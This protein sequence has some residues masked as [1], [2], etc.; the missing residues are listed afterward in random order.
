MITVILPILS[1]LFRQQIIHDVYACSIQLAITNHCLFVP[2]AVAIVAGDDAVVIAVAIAFSPFVFK[3]FSQRIFILFPMESPTLTVIYFHRW[4]NF[5]GGCFF[6]LSLL[7]VLSLFLCG[8]ELARLF[9]FLIVYF[10]YIAVLKTSDANIHCA[11]V[12]MYV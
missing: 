12:F 1:R 3:F 5:F 7:L 10:C 4:K 8:T 9:S 6:P 2:V 11:I